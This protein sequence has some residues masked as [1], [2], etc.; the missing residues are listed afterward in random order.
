MLETDLG[1]LGL[2]A[3]EFESNF[4][5]NLVLRRYTS[6]PAGTYTLTLRIRNVY[7]TF[8]ASGEFFVFGDGPS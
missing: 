6:T 3:W 8:V 4:R 5:L 2:D 1:G 7:G